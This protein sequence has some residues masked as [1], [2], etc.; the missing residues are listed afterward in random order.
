MTKTCSKCKTEYSI[1]HFLR[2]RCICRSC[3]AT[4]TKE[5][6]KKRNKQ[7]QLDIANGKTKQC[8]FCKE[9]KGYGDFELGTNKCKKCRNSSKS[10]SRS[11]NYQKKKKEQLEN[12]NDTK[13][14][15]IC[16]ATK[17]ISYFKVA[18]AKC[19]DCYNEHRREYRMKKKYGNE[20]PPK[21]N[22]PNNK[23]CKYCE[24][25]Q[26]KENFRKNRQKCLD[27]ERK[28][29]RE[30]RKSEHGKEKSKTWVNNNKKRMQ[31]LQ[32]NHYQNNKEKINAKYV[33]RYNSDHFFKI[34]VNLKSRLNGVLKK[35][36]IPKND[37]TMDYI[38]CNIEYIIEWFKFCFDD[39]M[40]MKNHGT[41][42]HIDH[43]IPIATFDLESDD[44]EVKSCFSW[45]NLTPMI[46]KENMEKKAKIDRSQIVTH[47]NNLE[48]FGCDI[49]SHY[50]TLCDLHTKK[51]IAP[52]K[53][54]C[55]CCK[56]EINKN[57]FR[58]N[59]RKC[60]DCEK[61]T[62]LEYNKSEKG[63]QKRK[64]WVEENKEKL[65]TFHNEY[66]KNNKDTINNRSK[67]R[68]NNS[69]FK[70][71]HLMKISLKKA[72]MRSNPKEKGKKRKHINCNSYQIQ[73]WIKHYLT[74]VDFE[75]FGDY[76]F[77]NYAIPVN[78]FDLSKESDRVDRT[79]RSYEDA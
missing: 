28:D 65:K 58:T 52:K 50:K 79:T 39:E 38:G 23:I 57:K 69:K 41:Y 24:K 10:K 35:N 44:D 61:K 7:R 74:D 6:R 43:V 27:C 60:K 48:M 56:K 67:A 73:K 36:K 16:K 66:Y 63:K 14:C 64:D 13:T 59:R 55:R 22:D 75:D 8:S 42:W 68:Y 32:S 11:E 78:F 2:N 37:R 26:T 4:I 70:L 21:P 54:T 15:T 40:T 33:K 51:K 62:D 76:W 47:I 72:V 9:T 45:Y 34:K 53:L 46:G 12:K 30:F 18:S 5:Q 29:G 49:P 71:D 31:Q 20:G 19:K 1:D 3:R 25:E 17:Q 77:A